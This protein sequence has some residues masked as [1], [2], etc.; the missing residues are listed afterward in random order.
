MKLKKYLETPGRP[1]GL[2][3]IPLGDSLDPNQ[4]EVINRLEA[5]SLIEARAKGD[6]GVTYVIL[7]VH[8]AVTFEPTLNWSR[9]PNF[10][11]VTSFRGTE[12]N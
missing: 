7:E 6:P 10:G 5:L 3:V 11:Q 12:G 2:V 8:D 1:R 4:L 9:G